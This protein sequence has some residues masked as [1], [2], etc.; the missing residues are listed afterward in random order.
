VPAEP[1]PPRSELNLRVLAQDAIER[2]F[3][4]AASPLQAARL[5]RA[6]RSFQTVELDP[7]DEQQALKRIEVSGRAMNGMPPG[8]PEQWDL[9]RQMYDDDSLREFIRWAKHHKVPYPLDLDEQLDSPTWD[10]RYDVPLW[11]PSR[12]DD[13]PAE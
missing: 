6:L 12:P 3:D 5:V 13:E 8:S 1:A 4:G 11:P 9:A 2:V 7:Y 10:T